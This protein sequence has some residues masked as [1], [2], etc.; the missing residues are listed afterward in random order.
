MLTNLVGV[1][2]RGGDTDS[3]GPVVVQVGQLVRQLLQLLGVQARCVLK[4]LGEWTENGDGGTV[5]G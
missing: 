5:P 3:A 2:T 1:L 4:T